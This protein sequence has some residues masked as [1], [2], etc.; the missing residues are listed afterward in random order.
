MKRKHSIFFIFSIVSCFILNAQEHQ[1]D[2]AL[3]AGITIKKKLNKNLDI[4]FKH[5]SRIGN[6][7][8]TYSLGYVKGGVAY[9]IN[10]H[11]KLV[12][13]YRYSKKRRRDY[14]FDNR[15][16]FSGAVIFKYKFNSSAFLYRSQVQAQFKDMYTSENG[17]NAEWY[18]RNKLTVKHEINKRIN[19]YLSEE[20][21]LPFYQAKQKGLD[22]SRSIIGLE[23]ALSKN[24][25]MD[26]SFGYQ[27]ELNS[28][29]TT[30]RVF[31]YGI[32]FTHQF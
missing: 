1:D 30:Q 12:G 21:F 29:K 11:I 32:N 26:L 4:Y 23:Y 6:N 15:N 3:W 22:R 5:Q 25:E 7:F 27:H 24:S 2:A 28:F 16:R 19:G 10:R 13:E 14:S 31:I 18:N 17:M 8:S 9:D 20:L